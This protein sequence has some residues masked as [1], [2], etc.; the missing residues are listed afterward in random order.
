MWMKE[1]INADE[2]GEGTGVTKLEIGVFKVGTGVSTSERVAV[3]KFS[4]SGLSC[5]L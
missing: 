2:S 3:A 5:L 4:Q 1:I